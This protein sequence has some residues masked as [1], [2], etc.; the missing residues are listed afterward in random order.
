MCGVMLFVACLPALGKIR[1]TYVA[2]LKTRVRAPAAVAF[3]PYITTDNTDRQLNFIKTA[4]H[5]AFFYS[6]RDL[7]MKHV[8][9]FSLVITSDV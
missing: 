7:I 5:D 8:L 1:A 2:E 6:F 9:G 4:A 3:A